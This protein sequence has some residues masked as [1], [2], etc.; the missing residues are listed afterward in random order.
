MCNWF[1]NWPVINCTQKCSFGGSC[2]SGYMSDDLGV[3]IVLIAHLII[4]LPLSRLIL[5]SVTRYL[6]RES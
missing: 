2:R 3:F 6:E 4:E 5:D 1:T